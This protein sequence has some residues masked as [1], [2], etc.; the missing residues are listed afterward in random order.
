MQAHGPINCFTLLSSVFYT[1]SNYNSLFK[2]LFLWNRKKSKIKLYSCSLS[3]TIID[4]VRYMWKHDNRQKRIRIKVIFIFHNI[5]DQYVI[6]CCWGNDNSRKQYHILIV[7]LFDVL[8]E[9]VFV[10]D[11]IST[12]VKCDTVIMFYYG[13]D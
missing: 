10:C 7:W 4:N 2:S 6:C 8:M 9:N 12:C 3:M 11:N 13:L 5:S 1:L